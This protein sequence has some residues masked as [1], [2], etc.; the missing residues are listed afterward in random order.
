MGECA[1]LPNRRCLHADGV[2]VAEGHQAPDR[3]ARAIGLRGISIAR[4]LVRPGR[5]L[6]GQHLH[7]RVAREHVERAVGPLADFA[8]SRV[9]LYEQRLLGDD[10]LAVQHEPDEPLA[11]HRA[12]EEIALPLGEQVAGIERHAGRRDRRHPEVDRLVDAWLGRLAAAYG[13][14]L[15]AVGLAS[16]VLHAVRHL[17]PTVV[18]AGAHDV[19]LVA[20]LWAVVGYPELAGSGIDRGAFGI[21][22]A[23]RVRFARDG[24]AAEPRVVLRDRAVGVDPDH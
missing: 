11:G 8:D 9:E 7:E 24:R 13:N 5:L 4:W 22:E 3:A 15:A 23:V 20:A 14:V 21:L 10:S 16:V 1:R 17:W 19:Y 18:V 6:R 2:S 12:D